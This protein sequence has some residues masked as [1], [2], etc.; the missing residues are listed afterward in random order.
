MKRPRQWLYTQWRR[1]G[2]RGSHLDRGQQLN[3]CTFQHGRV[4]P[5]RHQP[6]QNRTVRWDSFSAPQQNAHATRNWRQKNA[7][8]FVGPTAAACGSGHQSQRLSLS[9]SL[10]LPTSP[11]LVSRN[12][13]LTRLSS[14]WL[15][16]RRP[17]NQS[18]PCKMISYY[19]DL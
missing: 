17:H 1:Q 14:Q 13:S 4:L 8:I 3:E 11:Q 5:K 12:L 6:M 19:T 10:E 7:P 9:L 2:R 16:T 18:A 15:F